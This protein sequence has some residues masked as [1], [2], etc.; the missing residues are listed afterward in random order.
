[1]KTTNWMLGVF[2]AGMLALCGC[3]KSGSTTDKNLEANPTIK[4]SQAF[5][6]PTPELQASITKV[7]LTVR[8]GQY[9]EAIVELDKLANNPQLTEAQKKAVNDMIEHV[10]KTASGAAGAAPAAK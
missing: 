10:K 2:V 8:Y 6:T 7:M 9:P 3:G 5:P 4:F 1:M